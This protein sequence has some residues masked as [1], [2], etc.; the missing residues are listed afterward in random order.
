[1]CPLPPQ[2]S[3]ASLQ[4]I[5]VIRFRRRFPC[6]RKDLSLERWQSKT[7]SKFE[8]IFMLFFSFQRK[9]NHC[10]RCFV[11][12]EREAERSSRPAIDAALLPLPHLFENYFQNIK[13][14]IS[15]NQNGM[16]GW[17]WGRGEGDEILKYSFPNVYFA[18]EGC[19]LYYY[20]I[21]ARPPA[22][23]CL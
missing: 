23:C 17:G 18:S 7:T 2:K 6:H 9:N 10:L 3:L 19:C 21:L 20:K 5:V 15:Q 1:M 11:E 4:A 22:G 8:N 16:T 12:K 14:C 13:C